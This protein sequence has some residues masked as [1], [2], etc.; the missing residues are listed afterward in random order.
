MLGL[1]LIFI[2]LS[3]DRISVQENRKLVD[4]PRVSDIKRH[5]GTFIREFDAWFKDSTGFREKL[6][7]LY[8]KRTVFI[9]QNYYLDG[10]SI[11]FIGK[12]GHHFHTHY[13]QL[14]PIWQGKRWL[15]DTQSYELSVKLNKINQYLNERNIPFIVMFCT[16]KESIYPEFYP[17]FVI[18]GPEPTSLDAVVDYISANTNI[19]FFCIKE[20]LLREKE[21]WLLYPKT[22]DIYELCH[23]NET[24]SFIACL[25]LMGHINKYFPKLKPLTFEDVDITYHINGSSSVTLKNERNYDQIKAR[26]I[27]D[28]LEFENKDLNLPTLLLLHDSYAGKFPDYLPQYFGRVILHHWNTLDY[29]EEYIGKYK[30]DIVVF[31]SAERAIPG[32]AEAVIGITELP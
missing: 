11:V 30:P 28:A 5:P 29:F 32:F 21:N 2:D 15:D 6:I 14:L 17:D 4:R 13:N 12:Q 1:P 25:E 27:D 10:T 18:K 26:F 20:N 31:E 23:Y 16:D 8:K 22:G 19:D 7:S 9:G 3:S 24:G